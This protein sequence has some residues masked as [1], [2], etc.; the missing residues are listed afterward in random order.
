MKEKSW[1][2]DMRLKGWSDVIVFKEDLP[3]ERVLNV[4]DP[5]VLREKSFYGV[6]EVEIGARNLSDDTR[7]E[8]WWW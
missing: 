4:V 3:R 8:I 6:M 2:Y 1:V 5:P 7:P